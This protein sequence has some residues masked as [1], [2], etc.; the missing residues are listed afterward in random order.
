MNKI[1][2]LT[3]LL[4]LSSFGF[5][6][7]QTVVINE[8]TPRSPGNTVLEINRI[9]NEGYPTT[10]PGGRTAFV[11]PQV[12]DHTQLPRYNPGHNPYMFHP[13]ESMAGMIMYNREM[14]RVLLYDGRTWLP[15]FIRQIG[16]I[17]KFGWRQGSDVEVFGIGNIYNPPVLRMYY[18]SGRHIDDITF[19]TTD[20]FDEYNGLAY[21]NRLEIPVTGM[22]RVT[23]SFT[24]RTVSV[25]LNTRDVRFQII[26]NR[27]G[28]AVARASEDFRPNFPVVSVN[29]EMQ[30]NMETVFFAEA[31][32]IINFQVSRTTSAMAVLTLDLV[33][34]TLFGVGDDDFILIERIN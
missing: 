18:Q 26:V 31:G 24:T 25:G 6:L 16:H 34:V 11:I 33:G 14:E 7:A 27:N 23:A 28:R 8:D 29:D 2:F 22:Y 15:A 30:L 13:D 19:I 5:A 9:P 12:D 4:C 20:Q 1:K 17:S 10:N 32:D 21:F 3:I